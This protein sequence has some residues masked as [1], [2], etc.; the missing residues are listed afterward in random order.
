MEE[1]SADACVNEM[2]TLPF[3][4]VADNEVGADGGKKVNDDTVPVYENPGPLYNPNSTVVCDS[5]VFDTRLGPTD[6]V[7]V[8]VANCTDEYEAE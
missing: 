7:L 5:P 1:P 8:V 3:P 2:D 6:P 4:V